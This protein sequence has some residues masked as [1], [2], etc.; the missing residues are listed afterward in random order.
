VGKKYIDIFYRINCHRRIIYFR[1]AFPATKKYA[2]LSS[3]SRS[4]TTHS[5]QSGI[6]LH[7]I[8]NLDA[9]RRCFPPG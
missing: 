8:V 3:Y 9:I 5:N 1:L 2:P 4:I 6:S 7:V